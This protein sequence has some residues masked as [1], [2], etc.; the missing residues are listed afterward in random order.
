MWYCDPF[1]DISHME[2][3]EILKRGKD[4]DFTQCRLHRHEDTK[5]AETKANSETRKVFD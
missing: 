4:I 5:V 2:P 1:G 3:R